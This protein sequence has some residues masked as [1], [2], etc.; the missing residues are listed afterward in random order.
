M[1]KKIV[2]ASGSPRRKELLEQMGLSFTVIPAKG[3]ERSSASDPA[4]MVKELALRKA[5]EVAAAVQEP[6]LV[7]GSDTV[8]AFDGEILG[9]PVDE[10]DAFRMLKLLQGTEH[11][12]YTGVAVVDAG[13]KEIVVS[14]AE[15]TVVSMYPMT[16]RWIW[17]YIRSGEPMDK[18]G[19][20]AI[21]GGCAPWIRGI[22]GE[23]ANVVGFPVARFHQELLKKGIDLLEKKEEKWKACIFDLDGTLCDS[24]ES[25]AVCA[26]RALK[27]LG[28]KEASLKEYRI[29]VGD[30]VDMLVQRLL[31]FAGIGEDEK[32]KAELGQELKKRYMDYFR[33]GCMYHVTP[34]PGILEALKRL[35]EQG[36]KIGVLSNKPH[37][38]TKKVIESV[39][40]E[41]FFDEILGQK[42]EIP[43]KPDPT[44]ALLLAK[45][46]GAGPS[47][48]LYVG[49]T[50][51]DMRTGTA[52]GMYT[53]GV[54][55]GFRD[56]K[57]LEET[58]AVE[59]IEDPSRLTEIY[60]ENEESV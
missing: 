60:G 19:A 18:A 38:N 22:S 47:E 52:A 40:G 42:E 37:A 25:I 7:I 4:V 54:L 49:D 15:G 29:F 26:N 59:V 31:N 48:C 34:Y 50:G 12:V 35:K 53:V 10:E 44:G 46:L 16:E 45:K 56:R 23:Y 24:V 36:A 21:Q 20:Y 27:E 17:R 43:R 6:A 14:F 11:V 30:G 8:V 2:L 58:G 57:E 39:F 55:W 33:E 5:M 13:N 51:T 28:L 32:R 3:E 9:K 1:R 41:G